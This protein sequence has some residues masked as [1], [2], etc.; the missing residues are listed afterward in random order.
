MQKL[1]KG[2]HSC[3]SA[4]TGLNLDSQR[5]IPG[6]QKPAVACSSTQGCI[7][8][9]AFGAGMHLDGHTCLKKIDRADDPPKSKW[10]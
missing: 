4:L 3:C 2:R 9:S 10:H 6:F 7:C 8:I 1:L 5:R